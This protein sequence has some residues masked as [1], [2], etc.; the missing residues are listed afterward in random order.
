MTKASSVCI[1]LTDFR[2]YI[3][4]Y[5][6]CVAFRNF[7]NQKYDVG[8]IGGGIIGLSTAQEL[9]N[10]NPN[11]KY[12]VLEKENILGNYSYNIYIPYYLSK[13]VLDT[14]QLFQYILKCI[15]MRCIYLCESM[16]FHINSQF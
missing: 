1:I 12:I 2:F 11:L 13:Q 8:I 4:I 7:H 9:I 10:R 5:I 3:Y 14:I 6:Y 16:F 15:S